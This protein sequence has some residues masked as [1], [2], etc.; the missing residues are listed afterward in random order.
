MEQE[1][2]QPSKNHSRSAGH[3]DQILHSM[4]AIV[5]LIEKF[6]YEALPCCIYQH[7][8]SQL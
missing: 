4:D 1:S 6:K 3:G 7:R 5:D 2:H 8:Y